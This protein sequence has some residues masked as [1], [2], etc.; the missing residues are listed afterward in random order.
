MRN[1]VLLTALAGLSVGCA[2]EAP[3]TDAAFSEL[4]RLAYRDADYFD[5]DEETQAT[6]EEAFQAHLRAMDT[7][8]AAIMDI[9]KLEEPRY[10]APEPLTTEYQD[11]KP[12]PDGTDPVNQTPVAIAFRSAF[13]MADH[14]EAMADP[15]QNCLGSNSTKWADR[16]WTEGEDC[17]FDGSCDFATA[18]STSRTENILAKV[19]IDS[20][21]DFIRTTIGEREV[22]VS[23][24]WIDQVF[25]A[26][27]NENTTWS[28]RYVLDIWMPAEDDPDTTMR[29]YVFYSEANIPGV[30]TDLYVAQVRDGVQENFENV[31]EFLGGEE[32]KDR[33]K[34]KSDWE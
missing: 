15:N 6:Q 28:Q 13:P 34:P 14:V 19:W 29:L 12:Q 27:N 17:F 1:V 25:T 2:A 3:P 18:D 4:M 16:R 33:D 32:C 9:E 22:I 5:A 8:I 10:T 7:E 26:D 31:D 30:G 23:R 21:M 24:G 20:H 11:G